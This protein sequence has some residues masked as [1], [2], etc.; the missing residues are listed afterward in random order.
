MTTLLYLLEAAA[1]QGKSVW[2]LDRP[3][4]AG[5]PVEGTLLRPGGESFVGAGPLPMRHGLTLG[6]MGHWFVRRFGLDLDYRVIA[7]RRLG[8][9]GGARLRLAAESASGSTPAPT[10]P[11]STWPAPTR[12]R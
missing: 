7:M 3:N 5:R 8:A 1:G 10:P 4:P 2:V 6:E 11:A 12:E 9:G